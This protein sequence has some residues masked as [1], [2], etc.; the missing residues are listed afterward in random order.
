MGVYIKGVSKEQMVQFFTSM[1]P[2]G[3]F[4]ADS[5]IEVPE[6]HGRLIDV[7]GLYESELVKTLFKEGYN[8]LYVMSWID[9][10]PTVIE[11]EDE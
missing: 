8:G 3:R 6:P 5:I 11:S 2:F 7:N 9:A 10:L 1:T 4:N